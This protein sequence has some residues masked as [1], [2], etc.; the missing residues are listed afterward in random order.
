MTVG[1]L[2]AVARALRLHQ[3][4]LDV[5]LTKRQSEENNRVRVYAS[6]C[7]IQLCD[8]HAVVCPDHVLMFG[9]GVS[10]I[11]KSKVRCFGAFATVRIQTVK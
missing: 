10:S 3:R 6:L 11:L 1:G 9:N 2:T 5:W 7:L 4:Q 8:E